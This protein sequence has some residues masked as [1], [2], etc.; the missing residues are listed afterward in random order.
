ML[1]RPILLSYTLNFGQ[2]MR[3]FLSDLNEIFESMVCAS[4]I[5]DEK[6]DIININRF[7]ANFFGYTP[8]QI[9]SN[10]KHLANWEL[11]DENVMPL[12][13]EEFPVGYVLTYKKEYENRLIGFRSPNNELKWCT[14]RAVPI[15]RGDQ[16]KGVF[17]TFLDSTELINR[18]Q[19]LNVLNEE[20]KNILNLNDK[21]YSMISHDL[22]SPMATIIS[23][24]EMMKILIKSKEYE[25]LEEVVDTLD[26]LSN[27]T[28]SMVEGLLSMT[29]SKIVGNVM[30]KGDVHVESII[31]QV[32]SYVHKIM[33]S[34]KVSILMDIKYKEKFNTNPSLLASIIRNL[35]IN[36]I[37]FSS[38][39][40]SISVELKG[41]SNEL[42]LIIADHGIGMSEELVQK[43]NQGNIVKSGSGT[44]GETGSG[45]GLFLILDFIK[46]INSVYKITSKEGE[47]TTFHITLR[48]IK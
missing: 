10:K 18:N 21:I 39:G 27:G 36:S 33:Q 24:C 2:L 19:N 13:V 12:P 23:Y 32:V 29:K 28:L 14:A 16:L 38:P 45:I 43:I 8:E 3:E 35:L 48:P 17:V 31:E 41:D 25:K 11:L 20:L 9:I 7:G 40:T 42:D 1:K 44:E 34:K 22:R 5:H 47:G 4:V 30:E 37:K 46:K 15:M 26:H 6:G